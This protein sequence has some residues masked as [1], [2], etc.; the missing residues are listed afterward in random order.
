M[1]L[2][3]YNK[4]GDLVTVFE[5]IKNPKLKSGM[6]IFDQGSISDMTDNHIL[7]DDEVEVPNQLTEDFKLL[8]KKQSLEKV[9]TVED[10]MNQIKKQQTDLSFELMMK[11][12]L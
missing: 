5:E 11:G 12:V 6:L 4:S 2:A 1:K 9:A 7:I 10:E 8:D 3:L